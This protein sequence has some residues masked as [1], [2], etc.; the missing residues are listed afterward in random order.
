VAEKL[1][2]TILAV[3]I[4]L[5]PAA[6]TVTSVCSGMMVNAEMACCMEE[7]ECP[8]GGMA[9]EFASEFD[10]TAGQSI[11]LSTTR[12]TPRFCKCDERTR[13]TPVGLPPQSASPGFDHSTNRI[14]PTLQSLASG[15]C[16]KTDLS[17]TNP[18]VRDRSGTWLRYHAFLI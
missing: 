1:I 15:E 12:S 16:G 17:L 7:R 6:G 18:P 5:L 4:A 10:T 9:T 14:V 8:M 2:K 11:A 3:F 13:P